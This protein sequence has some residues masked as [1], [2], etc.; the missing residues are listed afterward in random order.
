MSVIATGT[1]NGLYVKD[2][3]DVLGIGATINAAGQFVAATGPEIRRVTGN[4]SGVITDFGGSLALDV[5]NGVIYVNTS[6]ANTAGTSWSQGATLTVAGSSGVSKVFALTTA[7]PD[8]GENSAALVT[9]AGVQFTFP[10]NTL[11]AGSTIQ[12]RFAA[13]MNQ[14]A[15]NTVVLTVNL[16]ATNLITTGALGFGNNT[17]MVFDFNAT[18]RA[19]GAAVTAASSVSGETSTASFASQLVSAGTINT[20]VANALTFT[21]QFNAAQVATNMDINQYEVYA[22]V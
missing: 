22:A 16:G 17:A 8:Q 3:D 6:K 14:G 12:I 2:L 18:I 7:I 1:S 11:S 10:A 15:A 5:T 21:L 9:P 20:T 4:P 13:N 19:S